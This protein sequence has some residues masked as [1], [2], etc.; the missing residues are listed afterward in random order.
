[1]A[2][3]SKAPDSKSGLGQ[4]NGGSNPSLSAIRHYPLAPDPGEPPAR[5]FGIDRL[6]PSPD[7]KDF[8]EKCE[9]LRQRDVRLRSIEER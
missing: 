5:A 9:V 6:D 3:R 8:E 1:M 4:P 2:E 7:P